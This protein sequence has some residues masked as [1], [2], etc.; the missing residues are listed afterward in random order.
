M[1]V[2]RMGRVNLRGLY[3]RCVVWSDRHTLLCAR[4]ILPLHAYMIESP[5]VGSARPGCVV[6][7]I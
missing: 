3:T 1:Y 4:D 7:L 2:D 6:P 5:L